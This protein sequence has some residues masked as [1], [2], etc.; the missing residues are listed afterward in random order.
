MLNYDL[1]DPDPMPGE[2]SRVTL[3]FAVG[4]LRGRLRRSIKVN[5]YSVLMFIVVLREEYKLEFSIHGT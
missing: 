4:E 2:N 1:V 5:I 3:N